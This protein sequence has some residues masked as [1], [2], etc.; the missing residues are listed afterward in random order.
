[1]SSHATDLAVYAKSSSSSI[2]NDLTHCYFELSIRYVND[3]FL[4][5][6]VP[7]IDL[8]ILF[9]LTNIINSEINI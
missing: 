2:L 4:V 3:C 9:V 6:T 8:V 7:G 1:M 5:V